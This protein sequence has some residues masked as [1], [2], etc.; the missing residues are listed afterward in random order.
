M[1]ISTGDAARELG[2]SFRRIEQLITTGR[3]PAQQVGGRWL[4]DPA[5][6]D[7]VRSRPPGRP[8]KAQ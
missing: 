6:L 4:I 8:R 5:D 7:R 2:V 1:L 3:L